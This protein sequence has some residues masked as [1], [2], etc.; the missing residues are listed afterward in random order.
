MLEYL[1]YSVVHAYDGKQAV[2][3][4]HQYEENGIKIDLLILD[5]SVPDGMGGKDAVNLLHQSYPEAK[6]IVSSEYSE[7]D[8]LLDYARYGFSGMVIKPYKLNE[9]SKVLARVAERP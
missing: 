8:V 7:D 4:Y 5:L 6:A 3:I 9:L 1:G 2:N